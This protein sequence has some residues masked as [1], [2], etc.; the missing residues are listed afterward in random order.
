MNKFHSIL[1]RRDFMKTVGL[2]T[3]GI[4]AVGAAA[5]VF[6]NF[7]DM[8][9]SGEAA[10]KSF[11]KPWYI[12]DRPHG[13]PTIEVDWTIMEPRENR[14]NLNASFG[15]DSIF[16]AAFRSEM[17]ALSN[18]ITTSAISQKKGGYLARDYAL[19]SAAQSG[20]CS[21]SIAKL[22]P[23]AGLAPYSGTPEENSQLMRAAMTFLGASHVG[24]TKLSGD[25]YKI[26]NAANDNNYPYVLDA[27]AEWA[28]VEG[29]GASTRYIVPG[30]KTLYAIGVSMQMSK[31]LFKHEASSDCGTGQLRQAANGDRYRRWPLLYAGAQRFLAYLGYNAFGYATPT[32]SFVPSNGDAV[33]T[34]IA[35]AARNSNFTISPYFGP[36]QGVFSV[37]T[38]MP[39][40]PSHC[41]DAGIFRFCRT[42]AKCA[43]TCPSGAIKTD[44]FTTWEH[45][46]PS[47]YKYNKTGNEVRFTVPG[48]KNFFWDATACKY[49]WNTAGGC[50][51]CMGTCTFNTGAGAGVHDFVRATL[52]TTSILNGFFAKADD[53]YYGSGLVSGDDKNDWWKKSMPVSAIES[54]LLAYDNSY[55]KKGS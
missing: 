21:W 4:A 16:G 34:G 18:N 9:S 32:R 40:A 42:C 13:D 46:N 7:D 45:F 8:L 55:H 10:D 33:F 39:L 52:A 24:F 14:Y 23:A 11:K 27:N 47:D 17:T 19:S 29:S 15:Q 38:D 35:E 25:E 50:A 37:V 51:N 53:F 43:A 6:G 5:P 1:S 44:N 22:N 41:I 20:S 30:K 31:E 12:K 36:V 26:T 28:E 48:K 49:T 2:G 3:A 54:T